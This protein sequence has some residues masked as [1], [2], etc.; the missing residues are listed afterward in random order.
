MEIKPAPSHEQSEVLQAAKRSNQMTVALFA[1]GAGLA[2][3]WS[4]VPEKHKD[5]AIALGGIA[6]GGGATAIRFYNKAIE[7][8]RFDIGDLDPA[9][10][11][12]VL[13]SKIE[14]RRIDAVKDFIEGNV[15]IADLP[16]VKQAIA[17][18]I[19]KADMHEQVAAMAAQQAK[20]QV[21]PVQTLLNL[22]KEVES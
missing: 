7:D 18:Q 5:T 10:V 14:T 21:D 13:L 11:S 19:P 3:A 20:R 4:F 2:I 6:L 22:A 16:V 8:G 9:I 17:A 12:R 1:V 15:D